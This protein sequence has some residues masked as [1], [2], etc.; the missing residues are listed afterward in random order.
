MTSYF[1]LFVYYLSSLHPEYGLCVSRDLIHFFF[2]FFADYS[3]YVHVAHS[4][5]SIKM[6][7]MNRFCLT[8]GFPNTAHQGCFPLLPITIQG[9][10]T[11]DSNR[12]RVAK[13]LRAVLTFL[14]PATQF[15]IHWPLSIRLKTKWTD[16][17][18]LCNESCH[19]VPWRVKSCARLTPGLPQLALSMHPCSCFPGDGFLRGFLTN[20][21]WRLVNF[22]QTGFRKW[23]WG[24]SA[25][26]GDKC[27]IPGPRRLHMLWGN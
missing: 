12:K 22:P 13:S 14:V 7:W 18:T 5:F 8:W 21:W 19:H 11:G 17:S 9:N 10:M 6:C 2:F 15:W 26:A 3:C 20:Y 27:S 24:L 23:L 25:N 16:L 4:R 1:D